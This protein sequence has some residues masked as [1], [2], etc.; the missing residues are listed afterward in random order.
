VSEIRQYP[1]TEE[2]VIMA[3]ERAKRPHD[4][5][6]RQTKPE[7]PPFSSPVEDGNKN[8]YLW[9]LRIIPRLTEV[10][11]FEIGSGININTAL[12]EETAQFM[13]EQKAE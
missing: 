3:R 11:G 2:W 7:L 13:R 10:A 5:I 1:T 9:H 6:R 4:F 8:Y 12:P